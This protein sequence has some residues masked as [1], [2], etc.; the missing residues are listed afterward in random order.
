MPSAG[1]SD[2]DRD[3]LAEMLAGQGRVDEAIAMLRARA[4]R[5]DD[6]AARLLAEVLA[7][8]GRV[9]EAIA[10]LRARAGVNFENAPGYLRLVLI[11]DWEAA[12]N[13]A[14]AR[15]DLADLLARNGRLDELR[16]RADVGDLDAASRLAD[17]LAEQGNLD[18]L[19][20]RADQ[21]DGNA[22]FRLADL[23]EE[24][25]HLNDARIILRPWAYD[26]NMAAVDRLLDL[27]TA[28]PR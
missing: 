23:L 21:Y 18:E 10:M 5:G 14:Y 12:Q 13:E 2:L 27:K 22:I 1:S 6:S 3:Q 20:I 15:S 8:Q 7:G 25:G 19:R 28:R 11:F 26:G 24:A 9:D 17:L 4:D 16:T